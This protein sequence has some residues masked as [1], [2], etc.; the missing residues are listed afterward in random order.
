MGKLRECSGCGSGY[1]DYGQRSSLCKQCRRKYDRKYHANR[2]KNKKTRKQEL[3]KKRVNETILKLRLYKESR[4]CMDCGESN[5]L[6]L[7]F[8]H[9]DPA[10][11]SF[12]I[13]SVA[14]KG[15]SLEVLYKEIDKCDVV[16]ANCHRIRTAKQLG[17]HV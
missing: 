3:Q 10:K 6:V 11:K 12:T 5:P 16:C 8:D 9:R 17:W 14:R 7:D 15:W 2:S 13:G 1:D 4:G